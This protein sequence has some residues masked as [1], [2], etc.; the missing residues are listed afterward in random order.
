M[1]RA[2]KPNQRDSHPQTL[3]CLCILQTLLVPRARKVAC[4]SGL[5]TTCS[6][7]CVQLEWGRKPSSPWAIDRIAPI[8]VQGEKL[9]LRKAFLLRE[10]VTDVCVTTKLTAF[11]LIESSMKAS[12]FHTSSQYVHGWLHTPRGRGQVKR[13][14]QSHSFESYFERKANRKEVFHYIF[15]Y[16]PTRES[17]R[18]HKL[19]FVLPASGKPAVCTFDIF[20]EETF[21]FFQKKKTVWLPSFSEWNS[22]VFG[23]HAACVWSGIFQLATDK[24]SSMPFFLKFFLYSGPLSR[25][26]GSQAYI[27][28]Q[29]VLFLWQ[30]LFCAAP[31]RHL[32]TKISRLLRGS[33]SDRGP[34]ACAKTCLGDVAMV[35]KWRP[36]TSWTAC[37]SK[38]TVW[39][40]TS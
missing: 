1:W 20:F 26:Q 18:L 17:R 35:K 23:G 3:I 19:S 16:S 28:M 31:G 4:E 40:K 13:S 33:R 25:V 24:R 11:C 37:S 34:R 38:N 39:C 12:W 29:T 10:L 32:C 21:T 8:N 14:S 9:V 36:R 30:R 5:T 6:C 27:W 22:L 7:P 15:E 2:A